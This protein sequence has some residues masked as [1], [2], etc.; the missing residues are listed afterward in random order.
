M[1][2]I[3]SLLLMFGMFVGGATSA[4]AEKALAMDDYGAWGFEYGRT[5]EAARRQAFS[6]C[7][8][9]GA[10]CNTSVAEGNN[11]YFSGVTCANHSYVG[12]SPKGYWRSREIAFWKAWNNGDWD[13]YVTVDRY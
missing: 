12:A 1:K 3:L 11:W 8:Y 4:S 5:Q 6:T 2:L 7:S 9:Y 13:C 10:S